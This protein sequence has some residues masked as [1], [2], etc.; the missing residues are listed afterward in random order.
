MA[1]D[2]RTARAGRDRNKYYKAKY[3]NNMKLTA[4][5]EMT[6]VFYSTDEEPVHKSVVV[7]GS[8]RHKQIRV[9]IKTTDF[10]EDL[11]PD[12]YV[13]YGG[14][15]LLYIVEDVY[16]KDISDEAKPYA[17]HSNAYI[18]TMRR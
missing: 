15:G 5:A 3:V 12:D 8:T 2:T 18:I 17:R 1:I 6:G 11:D 9:K 4:E 16:I 10:V 7:N 14:D 13:L